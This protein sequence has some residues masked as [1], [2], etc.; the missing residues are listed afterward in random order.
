M[1][2]TRK[3]PPPAN[4]SAAAHAPHPTPRPRDPHHDAASRW[5]T[6]ARGVLERLIEDANRLRAAVLDPR[7]PLHEAYSERELA[8]AIEYLGDASNTLL[9]ADSVPPCLIDVPSP[10]LDD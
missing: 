8:D 6:F 1:A 3:A 9:N 10:L 4:G 2:R 5:C 7:H